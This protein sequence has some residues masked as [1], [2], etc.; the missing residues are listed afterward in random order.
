MFKQRFYNAAVDIWSLGVVVYELAHG[1][2]RRGREW[3][4]DGIRWT[5]KIVRSPKNELED[6]DC[7]LLTFLA[8]GMLVKDPE[9]RHSARRCSELADARYLDL[10]YFCCSTTTHHSPENSQATAT[11]CEPLDPSVDSRDGYVDSDR[12]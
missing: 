4:F 8:R 9:L 6:F 10:S 12:L 2:P 7:H 1:L 11:S 5:E 3:E